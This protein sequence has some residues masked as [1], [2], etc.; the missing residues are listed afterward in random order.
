M[1]AIVAA[2]WPLNTY[3][4][5][6]FYLEM[7]TIISSGLSVFLDILFCPQF[8][9]RGHCIECRFKWDRKTAQPVIIVMDPGS[10]HQGTCK[11]VFL[12]F[13]SLG[14]CSVDLLW[15]NYFPDDEVN[16]SQERKGPLWARMEQNLW[17]WYPSSAKLCEV[18]EVELWIKYNNFLKAHWHVRIH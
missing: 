3:I 10:Q 16:T 5:R 9:S 17:Y 12:R 7:F 13:D 4:V 2:N 14:N 8:Y 11:Y 6:L 18:D 1:T 15:Q